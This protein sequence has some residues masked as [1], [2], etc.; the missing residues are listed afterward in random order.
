MNAPANAPKPVVEVEC[1]DAACLDGAVFLDVR[2]DSEWQEGH[3]EGAK[4]LPLGQ[5]LNGA[6]CGADKDCQIVVY[7]K[8]GKRGQAAAQY[9]V[10]QGFRNVRNLKG[11]ILAWRDFTA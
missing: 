5:L 8:A 10:A 9:L 7:C 3:I 2:E 6:P 11:G 4:H 1:K